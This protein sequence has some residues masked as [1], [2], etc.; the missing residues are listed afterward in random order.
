[1]LIMPQITSEDLRT[2]IANA[3]EQLKSVEA[4]LAQYEK[5]IV[6]LRDERN[7]LLGGLSTA[8]NML[9]YLVSEPSEPVN[10]DIAP[11]QTKVSAVKDSAKH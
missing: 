8:Q 1:M 5:Q 9:N 6:V 11:A 2:M 7:Q 4:R 3:S 10:Q